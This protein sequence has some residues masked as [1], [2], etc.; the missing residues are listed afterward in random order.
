V[1]SNGYILRFAVIVCVTCALL[2]TLAAEV[3]KPTQKAQEEFFIK[4]KV[5]T[6]FGMKPSADVTI[7]KVLADYDK[8]IMVKFIDKDGNYVDAPANVAKYKYE[9]ELKRFG[10][11]YNSVNDL[12]GIEET[13]EYKKSP[14]KLPVYI[15]HDNGKELLYAVPI[16][17]KGLWSTLYGYIAFE[18]DFK[19][20]KGLSFYD[21]K[22]TPGLGARIEEEWFQDN[23]AGKTIFNAEDKLVPIAVKKGTVD[24]DVEF[25]K[26]HMVDG[27]SGATIT[28]NGVTELLAKDLNLYEN[29]FKKM[30]LSDHSDKLS[31]VDKV[32]Q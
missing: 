10:F 28:C 15:R 6:V 24:P 11:K 2:L 20:V 3:L 5:L 17:G 26:K 1:H 19:T 7:K 25:E 23:F 22:E 29:Y 12:S 9:Q 16:V 21:H 32:E 18:N 8:N 4:K 13:K 27:I 31:S 30:A 14:L